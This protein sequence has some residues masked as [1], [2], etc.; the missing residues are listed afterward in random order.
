[1]T[2]IFLPPINILQPFAQ[3]SPDRFNHS[4]LV[5]EL[6]NKAKTYTEAFAAGQI[7]YA[8]YQDLLL[9]LKVDKMIVNNTKDIQA[10]ELLTQIV[11]SLFVI[12]GTLK[13]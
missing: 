9:D 11:N 13:L 7:S 8:E 5:A 4:P 2:L 12:L 10:K 6:A 1:M 3:L